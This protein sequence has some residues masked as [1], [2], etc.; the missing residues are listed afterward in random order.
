MRT[1]S[2]FIFLFF[3]NTCKE[4]TSVYICNSPYA[5]KYHNNSKCRGLGNC[6]YKVIS[7]DIEKAKKDG[8]VL[9]G[10]EK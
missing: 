1:L 5:K 6:T 9:C 10:W 4:T 3:N 2:L 8:K 7:I